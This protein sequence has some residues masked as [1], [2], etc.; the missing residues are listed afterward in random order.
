MKS[1]HLCAALGLCGLLAAAPQAIAANNTFC[2]SSQRT[3][4]TSLNLGYEDC[5]DPSSGSFTAGNDDLQVLDSS[6][7]PGTWSR[8]GL[9]TDAGFGPFSADPFGLSTGSL[10]LDVPRAD[11]FV[12]GL[13][14][15]VQGSISEFVFYLFDYTGK[16]PTSGIAFD[17]LGIDRNAN[18]G[19]PLQAAALYVPTAGNPPP[20]GQIPEPA[21]WALVLSGLCML[22][23]L[24]RSRAA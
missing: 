1:R 12:L 15:I 9:S 6:F 19:P 7:Q 11:R 8:L 16:S 22:E 5:V 2:T 10:F 4:N 21:T 17:T 24:R 20:P 3:D 14:A 18:P 13:Q 23:A